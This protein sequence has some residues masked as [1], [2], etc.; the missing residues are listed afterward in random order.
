M[1]QTL[2]GHHV[3]VSDKPAVISVT[4]SGRPRFYDCCLSDPEWARRSGFPEARRISRGLA[5]FRQNGA[6]SVFFKHVQYGDMMQEEL[7]GELEFVCL[8]CG[9]RSYP[10]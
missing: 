2:Y 8:K 9:H 5:V 4:V 6:R 7:L 10:D 3:L 1:D